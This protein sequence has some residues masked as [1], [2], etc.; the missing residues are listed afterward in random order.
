M[1]AQARGDGGQDGRN[2]WEG[3]DGAVVGGSGILVGMACDGEETVE[4]C[5]GTAPHG[6]TGILANDGQIMYS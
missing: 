2:E 1:A 3:E 4:V 6:G 5:K